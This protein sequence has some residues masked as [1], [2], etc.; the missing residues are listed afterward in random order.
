MQRNAE[1]VFCLLEEF[2]IN[3]ILSECLTFIQELIWTFCFQS[4][5]NKILDEGYTN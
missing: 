4:Q 3:I 5:K 1:F 2:F